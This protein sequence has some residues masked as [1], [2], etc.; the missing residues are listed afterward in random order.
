MSTL[1][2]IEKMENTYDYEEYVA[3]CIKDGTLVRDLNIFCMRVGVLGVAKNKYPELPEQ[4]ACALVYKEISKPEVKVEVK[5]VKVEEGCCGQ[6]KKKSPNIVIKEHN[7]SLK[8]RAMLW[9][10][11]NVSKC[12]WCGG[13]RIGFYG[14][15][16]L[17]ECLWLITKG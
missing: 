2:E 4:E 11:N 5:D 14:G 12:A 16:L 13:M 9:S 17:I 8:E 7:P 10:Y 1:R 3:V 6:G 15:I